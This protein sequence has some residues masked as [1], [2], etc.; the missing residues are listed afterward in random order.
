MRLLVL[1]DS[2]THWL[3]HLQSEDY[4]PEVTE[5]MVT[6]C[7]ERLQQEACKELFMECTK[8]VF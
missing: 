2:F 1:K 3:F 4:I 7:A 5:E 6:K 8:W